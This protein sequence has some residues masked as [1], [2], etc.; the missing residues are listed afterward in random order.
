[1]ETFLEIIKITIP[2]LIVFAT[3]YVLF[4]NFFD[5][6]YKLQVLSLRQKNT[7]HS[8]P[9]KLQAYERLTMLCER[10]NIPNLI[11]RLRTRDMSSVEMINSMILAVQQEYEH[12][13]TQQVYITDELWD[14]V[15]LAKNQVLTE[16][17]S[18]SS[19]TEKTANAGVLIQEL[20]NMDINS[21]SAIRHAKKAIKQELNLHMV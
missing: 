11:I 3:V 17:S 7:K 4:K 15:S 12:N 6:Q 8:I 18:F 2:A 9:L 10:I 20:T 19:L 16:I 14:I 13:L 1:M 21:A 5:Q